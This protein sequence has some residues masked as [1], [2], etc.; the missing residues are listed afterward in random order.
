MGLTKLQKEELLAHYQELVVPQKA[1]VLVSTDGAKESLTAAS[2]FEF[3][4]A[5]NANGVKLQIVKNTLIRKIFDGVELPDFVGQTF[6]AY[7]YDLEN[8]AD[9]VAVPK[10]VAES[11]KGLDESLSILGSVVNG[12]FYD[13]QKT[14]LL[15]KTPTHQDS[16]GTVAGMIKQV[17]GGK[18]ARLFKETMAKPTR[19]IAEVAK[20]KTA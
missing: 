15:S 8:D 3:R 16:M 20:T 19:A 18:L 13:K 5:N 17:A 7:K 10:S 12:E 4:K 1:V 2:N 9:E 14:I 11:I 6:V